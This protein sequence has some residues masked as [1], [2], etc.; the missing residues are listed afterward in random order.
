MDLCTF[1]LFA[2]CASLYAVSALPPQGA[3][4][5]PVEEGPCRAHIE[6]YYYNTMSQKCEVFYYGGCQGNANNFMGYHECQKT[7]FRI[8]KV[9]QMCRFPKEEGPCRGLF[10]RYFFNMTTMQC[11][12]FEY[13][14]CM[15]NR[16]RFQSRT[17]CTDYCGPRKTVPVLCQ[18]P[19]DKGKCSASIPRFYYNAATGACEE[20]AYTGCGGSSN[21]FVSQQTC[22]DVCAR[23]ERRPAGRGTELRTRRSRHNAATSSRA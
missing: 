10:S 17:T 20:F 8:P 23:G 16:N 14:G 15:G 21:N 6:R 22:T 12:P 11:E 19:L 5:L 7:C 3:C 1:A 18:G 9:P 4:L 2:A 13:G